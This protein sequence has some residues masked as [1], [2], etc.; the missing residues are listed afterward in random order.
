MTHK[1]TSKLS[2]TLPLLNQFHQDHPEVF[3]L[4]GTSPIGIIHLLKKSLEFEGKKKN[5]TMSVCLCI[6]QNK[7]QQNKL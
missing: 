7:K 2:C 5:K 4:E 1:H 6:N 3:L